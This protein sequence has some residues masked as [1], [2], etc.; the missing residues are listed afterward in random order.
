VS[1]PTVVV[2]AW[3]SWLTVLA[4]GLVLWT[5]GD[6]VEWA[7]FVAAAAGAWA[8]GLGL[9]ARRHLRAVR[10][11]PRFSPGAVL[12]ALG[13]AALVQGASLGLWLVCVGAGMVVVGLGVAVRE[14]LVLRRAQR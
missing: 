14:T 1:R 3:A 10:L 11:V 13:L 5:P 8:L 4:A 7:P 2:F 12:A 6:W 9:G